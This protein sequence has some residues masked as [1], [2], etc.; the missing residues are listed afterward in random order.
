MHSTST[1]ILEKESTFVKSNNFNYIYLGT[2]NKEH[3]FYRKVNCLLRKEEYK[4]PKFERKFTF[5]IK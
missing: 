2:Y 5:K 4:G 3:E 1:N